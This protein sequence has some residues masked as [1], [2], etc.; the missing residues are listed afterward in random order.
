MQEEI[1]EQP[2]VVAPTLRSYLPQSDNPI[3]L[4]L[5]DFDISKIRRVA[6]VAS[7]TAF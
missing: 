2:T 1:F 3:A 4:P 7:R 5:F 6:I